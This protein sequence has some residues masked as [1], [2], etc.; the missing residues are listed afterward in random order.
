MQKTALESSEFLTLFVKLYMAKKESLKDEIL[1]EKLR[2]K[3]KNI[4]LEVKAKEISDILSSQNV[5]YNAKSSYDE[6]INRI[7]H[8]KKVIENQ[9]G[10]KI[11]HVPGINFHKEEILQLFFKFVCT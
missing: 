7:N 4:V 5:E 9:D 2:I 6:A 3:K 8:L 10:Y 1:L 11:F